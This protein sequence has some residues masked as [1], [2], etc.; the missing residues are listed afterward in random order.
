MAVK[1][2]H[3]RTV[4]DVVVQFLETK[5]PVPHTVQA[6]HTR[7][8]SVEHEDASNWLAPQ[9]TEQGLQPRLESAVHLVVSVWFAGQAEHRPPGVIRRAEKPLS[10]GN[11]TKKT[12]KNI[13]TRSSLEC[14]HR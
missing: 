3:R 14:T 10:A 11:R 13:N 6:W 8:V 12:I 4:S 1:H 2:A 5:Y 7:S 9:G